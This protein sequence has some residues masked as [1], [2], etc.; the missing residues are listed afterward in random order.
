MDGLILVDKPKGITSHDVVNRIR[1]I[2]GQKKVGHFGT[3]D[4]LA[5]GLMVVAAGKAAKLF[6]FFLPYAK[7]YEGRIRLGISTDTYDAE[8]KFTSKESKNYPDRKKL[9]NHMK[10][11]EG[12]IEQ[13]SPPFSAKKY[14]GKPL[15]ELARQRKK[16][17][18]KTNLV[19]VDFFR[20][21]NYDPPFLDFE[22][23]CSSG[24]YIRSLA[25]DLG[26]NLGCGAHLIRLKRTNIGDF[27]IK[28]SFA[29]E[30][31][32]KRTEQGEKEDFFLPL[33]VLLP[34][35]PRVTVKENSVS[36]IANGS[37]VF[38][39]SL[40]EGRSLFMNG[41]R[42]KKKDIYRIHDSRGE[43]LALGTKDPAK[44]ALHPFL[45]LCSNVRSE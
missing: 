33:E 22:V 29:L 2:L 23:K 43:L 37:D 17:E 42:G 35:F 3:L 39:D 30:E 24:T 45:V 27:S 38:P 18:L 14:K 11:F 4:P 7:S 31:I 16:Y 12:E 44:N 21:K 25:H 41:S 13:I 10:R 28:E 6:P 40:T 26:E 36:L 32:E 8:G 1:K 15:Y 5:S 34:E 19:R 9:L 20:L